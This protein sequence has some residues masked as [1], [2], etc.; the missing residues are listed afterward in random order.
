MKAELRREAE[1]ISRRLVTVAD[2]QIRGQRPLLNDTYEILY[3]ASPR[4]AFHG[5]H[6]GVAS[7]FVAFE[8]MFDNQAV[9]AKNRA[10]DLHKSGQRLS[11]EAYV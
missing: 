1:K 4:A 7:G 11:S 2:R 6:S 5:N 10:L 8:K 9:S 3:F